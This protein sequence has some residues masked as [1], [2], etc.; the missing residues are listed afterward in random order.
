[1]RSKRGLL[2]AIAVAA[3]VFTVSACAEKSAGVTYAPL[4][5][6]VRQR[7]GTVTVIPVACAPAYSIPTPAQGSESAASSGAS[8]G[9]YYGMQ[10]GS[11][12]CFGGVTCFLGFPLAIV[13]G[14]V[15]GLVGAVAGGQAAHSSEEV[16][17]AETTLRELI[18]ATPADKMLAT[19]VATKANDAGFSVQAAP[20]GGDEAAVASPVE[21]ERATNLRIN[22]P[23]FALLGEGEID[24]DTMLAIGA[25]ATV[26]DARNGSTLWTRSWLY[27]GAERPFFEMANNDASGLRQEIDTGLAAVATKVV[28]DIFTATSE[29]SYPEPGRFRDLPA[30]VVRPVLAC[31]RTR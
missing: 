27:R 30:G 8:K 24:P 23:V 20:E 25:E 12:L 31:G 17:E 1:M 7:L 26:E 6:D 19:L 3:L 2:P 5:A 9:A 4:S 22:V 28:A 16:V 15:G 13:G 18:M 29:E 14:M 21:N 11:I 10:P